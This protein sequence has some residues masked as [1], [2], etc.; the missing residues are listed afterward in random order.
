MELYLREQ[1][2]KDVPITII[3]P[4][5]TFGEG[6]RNLGTFRQNYNIIHRLKENKPLVIFG[7]GHHPWTYSFAPDVAAAIVSLVG[8][9]AAIGEA[10]HVTG[11]EYTVWED[12]Y[13]A[14]G[15]LIGVEPKLVYVSSQTL[16]QVNPDLCAHLLFEK[17]YAGLFDNSKRH[18]AVGKKIPCTYNLESG[19]K[20]VYESWLKDNLQVDEEKDRYEDAWVEK[21]LAFEES[22]KNL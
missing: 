1:I 18:A 21:I 15:K 13:R 7:D 20:L 5:L 9:K 16:Y 17:S 12:L 8:V 11:D 14:F 4:S 22:V 2:A 19:V 6:T 3:R 10:F